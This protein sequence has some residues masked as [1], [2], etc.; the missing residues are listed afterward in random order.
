MMEKK[1]PVHFGCQTLLYG[2][3]CLVD[4]NLL[5]AKKGHMTEQV[6][7]FTFVS[8]EARRENMI[9]SRA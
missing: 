9:V 6:D 7:T 8:P 3:C 4:T 2:K 1:T 5:I